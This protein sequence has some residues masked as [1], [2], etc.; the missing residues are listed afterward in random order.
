[1]SITE[2]LIYF[3]IFLIRLKNQIKSLSD[4]KFNK[5][6]K[7]NNLDYNQKAYLIYFRYV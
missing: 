5:M 3:Y 6:L 1:M 7:D 4:Y 2:A